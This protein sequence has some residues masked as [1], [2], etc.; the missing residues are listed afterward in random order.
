MNKNR[1][2][3]AL[4]AV[5]VGL[6]GAWFLMPSSL[7][8]TSSTEIGVPSSDAAASGAAIIG[9]VQPA[10][11]EERSAQEANSIADG[12]EGPVADASSV[13][14]DAPTVLAVFEQLPRGNPADLEAAFAAEPIDPS[15]AYPS[16][17]Q[18][19][20]ALDTTTA[21]K[22]VVLMSREITCRSA[23]CRAVLTYA[24][25]AP[26]HASL[27]KVGAPISE[28]ARDL[29]KSRSPVS[30]AIVLHKGGFEGEPTTSEIYF[31][32]SGY[33]EVLDFWRT[34]PSEAGTR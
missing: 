24:E 2:T 30:G 31:A 20:R 14:G 34:P 17:S 12:E 9:T 7:D 1:I 32:R 29:A 5:L 22:Q 23:T 28:F 18:I 33:N 8:H 6:I 10:R 16:E 4:A 15:W 13:I 19:L 11:P 27:L 25:G 21:E 26:D 3:T